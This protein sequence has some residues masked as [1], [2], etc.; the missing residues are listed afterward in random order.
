[1]TLINE[2]AA[3]LRAQQTVTIK[4]K[5]VIF[6]TKPM[7][8]KEKQVIGGGVKKKILA[9]VREDEDNW[10]VLFSPTQIEKMITATG[11]VNEF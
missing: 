7:I 1:M 2:D 4:E 3:G 10:F 11:I 8:I 5:G 9:P 6:D